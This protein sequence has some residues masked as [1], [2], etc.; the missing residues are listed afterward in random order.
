MAQ[1]EPVLSVIVPFF[2][3]KGALPLTVENLVRVTKELDASVEILLVDDGSTDGGMESASLPAEVR[4]I[5]HHRNLGYGRAIGTGLNEAQGEWVVII[6][7]DGTYSPDDLEKLWNKREQADMIVG[8]R[9]KTDARSR[10]LVKWLLRRL[11][12]VLSE[13]KIPDLNSGLRLFRRDLALSYRGLFPDGFSL[14][15]T[16]TLAFLCNGHRVL[17]QPIEYHPRVGR[18]KIKPIGDTCGFLSLIVRMILFFNPLK[19]LVPLGLFFFA[20]ATAWLFFS[21]FVL[22][23]LMDVTVTVLYMLAV[24][25]A[26]LGFLA[27]LIVRRSK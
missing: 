8:L 19:V 3:E 5:R 6:D 13:E 12:E 18:S 25:I 17:Y 27:D 15:T 23:E 4:L 7:A 14:T 22:G 16:L 24:Q 26:L 21:K 20:L 2:N 11:A 9:A 10:R 1:A